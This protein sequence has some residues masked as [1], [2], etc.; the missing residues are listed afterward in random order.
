MKIYSA[1]SSAAPPHLWPRR[2]H[3]AAARTVVPPHARTAAQEGAEPTAPGLLS[4]LSRSLAPLLPP[5]AATRATVHPRRATT[6][7]GPPLIDSCAISRHSCQI[8]NAA[9]AAAVPLVAVAVADGSTATDGDVAPS[10][11]RIRRRY[12]DAKSPLGRA[13][14]PSDDP[15]AFPTITNHRRPDRWDTGRLTCNPASLPAGRLPR[16]PGRCP[17]LPPLAS[18]HLL[19]ISDRRP[20]R[21][22]ALAGPARATLNAGNNNVPAAWGPFWPQRSNAGS[23]ARTWGALF[24]HLPR[25]HRFKRRKGNRWAKKRPRRRRRRRGGRRKSSSRGHGQRTA[26]RSRE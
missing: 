16:C 2:P 1:A 26:P 7:L 24:K 14:S 12:R 23:T 20:L 11:P 6:S 17:A 3:P 5:R 18:L 15:P 10:L 8:N 22:S 25:I 9:V 21:V 4:T 19:G 13:G